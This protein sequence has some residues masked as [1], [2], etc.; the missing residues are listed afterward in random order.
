MSGHVNLRH[1]HDLALGCKRDDIPDLLLSII[2][3]MPLL[4]FT[5]PGPDTRQFRIGFD[6]Q[7]PSLVIRQMPVETIHLQKSHPVNDFLY[8]RHGQEMPAAVNEDAPPLEARVIRDDHARKTICAE[9][10]ARFDARRQHL[11]QGLHGIIR[12]GSALRF[13]QDAGLRYIHPI[14]F[15]RLHLRL[16]PEVNCPGGNVVDIPEPGIESQKTGDMIYRA[17]KTGVCVHGSF[18][19]QNAFSPMH[20]NDGHGRNDRR[21]A[22]GDL[23]ARSAAEQNEA[24]AEAEK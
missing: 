3:T 22:T 10:A 13:N 20:I 1:D 4:T 11:P 17:G 2:S 16:V 19:S 7:S 14:G 24:E 23:A 5:P 15:R 6:L 18:R 8:I 21:L 9:A 12:S